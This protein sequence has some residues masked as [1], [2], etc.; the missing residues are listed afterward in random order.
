MCWILGIR[1]IEARL[2]RVVPG[3]AAQ[4][5]AHNSDDLAGNNRLGGVLKMR[6]EV[7]AHGILV[8]EVFLRERATDDYDLRRGRYIVVLSEGASMQKWDGEGLEKSGQD[9]AQVA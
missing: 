8:G 7:A 2:I 3:I 9:R 5:V 4:S 6:D 1:Q